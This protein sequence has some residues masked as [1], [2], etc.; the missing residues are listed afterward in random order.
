M[1]AVEYEAYAPIGAGGTRIRAIAVTTSSANQDLAATPTEI[2]THVAAGRMLRLRADGGD[3]YYCFYKDGSLTIDQ[4]NTTQGNSA[5]CDL[6]PAGQFVDVRPPYVQ[7]AG[8]LGQLWSFLYYKGSVACTLRISIAS[9]DIG[10]R[11]T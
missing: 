5:Q 7:P 2:A 8:G 4:T 11:M 10:A 6:I 9:E 3:V 1:S